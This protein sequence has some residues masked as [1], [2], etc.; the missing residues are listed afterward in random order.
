[1]TSEM[2][3]NSKEKLKVQMKENAEVVSGA[4]LQ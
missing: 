4:N 2:R 1:M 3:G